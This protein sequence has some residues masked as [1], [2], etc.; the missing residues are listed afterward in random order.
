MTMKQIIREIVESKCGK[1]WTQK[2]AAVDSIEYS[3]RTGRPRAE[4]IR[5]L[6]N[7]TSFGVLAPTEHEMR[8]AEELY[9]EARKE[10]A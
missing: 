7:A 2:E 6:A 8:K 3:L 9:E 1:N 4:A 5:G 10:V